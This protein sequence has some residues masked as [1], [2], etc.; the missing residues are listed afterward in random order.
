[1]N[2]QTDR[3]TLEFII[4]FNILLLTKNLTYAKIL[5]QKDLRTRIYENINKYIYTDD[6]IYLCI[7]RYSCII[8]Q[9]Y[10]ISLFNYNL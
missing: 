6:T 8:T 10:Y 1:M 5:Y 7:Y 9:T 3:I 4:C 2:I